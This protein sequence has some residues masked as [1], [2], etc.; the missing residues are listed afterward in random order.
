MKMPLIEKVQLGLDIASC[1]PVIGSVTSII[2]GG[3][4][5]AQGDFAAAAL[6]FA[7]VIPGVGF[8]KAGVKAERLGKAAVKALKVEKALNKVVKAVEVTGGVLGKGKTLALKVV[9]KIPKLHVEEVYVGGLRTAEGVEVGGFR[10]FAVRTGEKEGGKV[11]KEAGKVKPRKPLQPNREKWKKNGGTVE[12]NKDGTITYT[13]K[14]GQPVTYNKDGYPDFTPYAHP[15]VEPVEIKVANPTN[16]PADFKAANEAAGLNKN[17]T[18][19]VLKPNESPEGY[20]WHH[21][22]DGKTMILVDEN[23]H[24]ISHTGGVSTVKNNSK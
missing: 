7:C 24:K 11:A 16:R 6:D 5:V 1:C 13:N 23:V 21:H 2:S 19:P 3:I 14:D 18:P 9:E 22:E 8:I 15:T 10:Y 17:S 4:S 20:T 12:E